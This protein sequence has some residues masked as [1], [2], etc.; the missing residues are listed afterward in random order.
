MNLDEVSKLRKEILKLHLKD[1][2]GKEIHVTIPNPDDSKYEGSRLKIN[3]NRL[4]E[5]SYC[6]L[7]GFCKERQLKL[8]KKN[9]FLTIY[10]PK[11]VNST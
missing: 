9:G 8:R 10:T 4:E 6:I 11:R 5:D 7:K 3:K 1:E 2:N